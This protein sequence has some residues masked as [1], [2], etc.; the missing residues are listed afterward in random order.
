VVDDEKLI[1]SVEP[2]LKEN[3]F[4]LVQLPLGKEVNSLAPQEGFNLVAH[5]YSKD[6][7]FFLLRKV[8]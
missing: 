4:L 7:E 2:S 1:S 8:K 5:K 6:R 3:A